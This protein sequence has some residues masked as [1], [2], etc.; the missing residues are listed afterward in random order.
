METVPLEPEPRILIESLRDIG[1]SFN[2]A[3]A[4][5]VDNSITAGASNIAI[6]AI[7]EEEFRIAIVDDGEGLSEDELRQA[8]RLGSTDPR[9]ERDLH[10]LGRFG[11]G[12]KTASFSQC[13]RLTVASR[14]HGQTHAFTWDLDFVVDANAWTVLEHDSINDIPFIGELG[15]TGTLVLWE[16]LD[17]LT[18]SRG[19]GRVNHT[20][21]IS[22][23]QDHL[24][25]VFHRFIAG[26]RGIKRISITVNMHLLESI[27]PF[28]SNHKATQRYDPERVCPGVTMQAFTLPHRSQYKS[29]A[30]YE[31]YG[32]RG[33]YLKSQGIYLYRAKRLIIHG[34]WF[35]LAKKTA[36]TQLAR[37][38][39]DIDVNQD[40]TW[41]IDVKKVSAQM[42]EVVRNRVKA[43]I[44]TIGTP[45][46]RTYR[47]RATRLTSPE[48]YP[49]WTP[50]RIGEKRAYRINR[51][52]PVIETMRD[53]L[54]EDVKRSFDAVLSLIESTFPSEALFFDL[55]NDEESVT[56]TPIEAEQF[57]EAA[58]TFFSALKTSGMR[59]EA[60][61]GIM[62]YSEP[63]MSNWSD[64]LTVLGIEEQ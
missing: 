5:I 50:E 14:K 9:A 31:R 13:R 59:D 61:L 44:M 38:K 30:E 26:E 15:E 2:S 36:L 33:G 53:S 25:L 60:I 39:I 6:L 49:T 52:H 34:T 11:L 64:T 56:S 47:K 8:M 40:E 29:A 43:L 16:K 21:I 54:D 35:G 10:D 3:L 46:R 1:Y 17:R 22:E 42:P 27:D 37:V 7:P 24:A 4:D 62:R 55:T 28:N 32:L 41:K 63:F 18:G 23:A 19:S 57:H 20:R 12:L 58:R 45:S 51:S 48:T